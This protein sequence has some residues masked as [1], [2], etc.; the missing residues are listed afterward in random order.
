[1][2]NVS[3]HKSREITRI[4]CNSTNKLLF[5]PPYSPQFNPIELVFSQ[6]K[7]NFNI[8]TKDIHKNIKNSLS[9]INAIHLMNYYNNCF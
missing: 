1:M 6:M 9:K 7:Q 3:F 8:N 5:I 4:F 2:D